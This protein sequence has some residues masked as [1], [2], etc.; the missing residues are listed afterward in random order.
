M[1]L[2][3]KLVLW[4]TLFF[5][6]SGCLLTTG[7][8]LLIARTMRAEADKFLEEEFEE[9]GRITIP[10]THDP[11]RLEQAIRAELARERNFPLAYRLHN[12]A[13]RRNVL[14]LAAE[15]LQEAL[16]AL[17]PVDPPPR[18]QR[19]A[20]VEFGTRGRLLRVL[21]E[22]LDPEQ[23]PGLV[24]QVGMHN[25]W[26]EKRT[27][28]LMKHLLSVLAA[29][30]V[31]AALGGW[32]LASRSLR[33]IDRIVSELSRIESTNLAARL[34][35]GSSG[36]EVDRLRKAINR[37]LERLNAAF[38]RLQTF[39]ADAAHELRTPI[40]ALQCRLEVAINK[41][42]SEAELREALS[43][44]LNQVAEL[45]ALVGNM[46]FLARMDAQPSLQDIG[47]V[48][49]AELL[50][51]IGEPFA[52][53]AEQQGVTLS[54]QA[55]EHVETKGNAV[56]LR[57]ILGNLLDNA[58]RYTP[59]GG[60]VTAQVERQSAGCAVAV[61]DTG[62]GI[63]PEA[64]PHVF[65]RFYR[66]DESRTRAA[67]GAGLGLSIVKRAVELH[68]GS[69]ALD[70]TPGK[71]TTVRVWLPAAAPGALAPRLPSS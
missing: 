50:R 20:W 4:Y 7:L 12:A 23:H 64:L 26:L 21:T 36:D 71:G 16:A 44:A 41:P 58:V 3:A 5:A 46:L 69:V 62:V 9:L 25:R 49:L 2:R 47:P 45:E 67:G 66:A 35:V 65:E 70:S 8:Y 28:S 29:E 48:D 15:G 33:P 18:D 56:L 57:R 27:A 17:P 6:V 30:I 38:D 10:L 60:R 11:N 22:P 19:F 32:V 51:D 53:L 1:S 63:E 13:A 42:R 54:I 40:A 14:A 37:M 39:T 24:L 68:G 52:L 31:V 55:G 43:E 61:T 34:A 59:A